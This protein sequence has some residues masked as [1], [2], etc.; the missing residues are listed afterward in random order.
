MYSDTSAFDAARAMS[1]DASD[2]PPDFRAS[3]WQPA[4]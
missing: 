3:L 4:Q 1:N 2:S